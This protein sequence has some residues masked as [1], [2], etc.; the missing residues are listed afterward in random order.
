MAEVPYTANSIVA[1]DDAARRGLPENSFR[2]VCNCGRNRRFVL[3]RESL[4]IFP[5]PYCFAPGM[6][7]NMSKP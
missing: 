3:T 7:L 6:M 5:C 4:D 1:C 2:V